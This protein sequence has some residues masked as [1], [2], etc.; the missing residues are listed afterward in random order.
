MVFALAAGPEGMIAATGNRAGLYRLDR[1][2]GAAQLALFPQGQITALAVGKGGALFA[3]SSN[4]AA[5]WKCGP[6]RASR[7]ELLSSV[8][9]ARRIATFGR[10]RWSGTPAQGSVR[11]ET[12]SGNCDP[13]DTTWSRWSGQSVNSEGGRTSSPPARYLQWVT[14]TVIDALGAGPLVS[15]WQSAKLQRVV[16]G[17]FSPQFALRLALKDVRLALDAAGDDTFAALASLANE[18]QL[19]VAAGLGDQD[20][21]HRAPVSPRG[22]G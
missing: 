19:V 8:L 18:W 15:P 13:P 5:I 11:L 7:G 9:D 12:R 2:G 3:A 21:T 10:I 17:D 6:E 20:L 22:I 14:Q 4:P 1:P 16:N